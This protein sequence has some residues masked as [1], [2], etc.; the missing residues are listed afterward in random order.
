MLHPN[1]ALKLMEAME[2]AEGF[3]KARGLRPNNKQYKYEL[4]R[5]MADEMNDRGIQLVT[6]GVDPAANG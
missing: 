5:R 4:V 6:F 3:C 1:V 2:A